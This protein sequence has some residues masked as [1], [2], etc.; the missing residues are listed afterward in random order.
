[1]PSIFDDFLTEDNEPKSLVQSKIGALCK[2]WGRANHYELLGVSRGQKSEDIKKQIKK[3][4][5]AFQRTYH[6]DK[7]ET[8]GLDEEN[9]KAIEGLQKQITEAYQT[10][11]DPDTEKEYN[12]SLP[13][14]GFGPTEPTT[15][16]YSKQKSGGSPGGKIP[17]MWTLFFD[18]SEFKIGF[19]FFDWDRKDYLNKAMSEK[20]TIEWNGEIFYNID[21]LTYAALLGKV[22]HVNKLLSSGFTLD[23]SQVEHSEKAK[24]QV[25]STKIETE[26]SRKEEMRKRQRQ[27]QKLYEKAGLGGPPK[28]LDEEE[29]FAE[30]LEK[31]KEQKRRSAPSTSTRGS[32]GSPRKKSGKGHKA[33]QKAKLSPEE[34]WDGFMKLS[35]KDEEGIKRYLE[36]Y[37]SEI[38]N[39]GTRI[40]DFKKLNADPITTDIF[41][42]AALKGKKE[43]VKQLLLAGHKVDFSKIIHTSSADVAAFKTID[44]VLESATSEERKII[45][46]HFIDTKVYYYGTNPP[47]DKPERVLWN[48][49]YKMGSTEQQDKLYSKAVWDDFLKIRSENV[50][51]IQRYL[52]TYSS[53]IRKLETRRFKYKDISPDDFIEVDIFTDAALS[54]E[55][56]HVKQLLLAGFKLDRSQFNKNPEI[57]KD[58]NKTIKS[59]L[60]NASVTE[61][62]K[63]IGSFTR[64]NDPVFGNQLHE[65]IYT[66]D[67]E[68]VNKLITEKEVPLDSQDKLGRTPL[69]IAAFKGYVEVVTALVAEDANVNARSSGGNTPLLQAAAGGNFQVVQFLVEKG[70]LHVANNTG[71]TPIQVAK[72]EEIKKFLQQ[73]FDEKKKVVSTAKSGIFGPL[74]D[75]TL[76]FKRTKEL[77]ESTIK[78]DS[79]NY[80]VD[81]A[82]LK[83]QKFDE[84]E[85][86]NATSRTLNCAI[87]AGNQELVD[88]LKEQ[89]IRSTS[90]TKAFESMA[91]KA[92]A[93]EEPAAKELE[94]KHGPGPTK[95]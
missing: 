82:V 22:E 54:G 46:Q 35:S 28:T 66:G 47:S 12:R 92:K 55:K 61:R 78:P 43:H 37:G 19:T 7:T 89:G 8:L 77:Y 32:K 86:E 45:Y 5:H 69:A 50:E 27:L 74:E 40:Y 15:P 29:K 73:T 81:M 14:S 85:L 71:K 38:N 68:R 13:D 60:K 87:L 62:E 42:Y 58:I 75:N 2:N 31:L 52:K 76:K 51:E 63:I 65:A 24:E 95:P 83:G 44:S 34:V 93:E 26:F 23:L 57:E 67:L 56:E 94:E 39:L 11:T 3:K 21:V 84:K 91:K 70:A 49:R 72:T 17:L 20:A 6:P 53:E 88:L 25:N 10:L 18:C 36:T 30:M 59:V 41:T 64:N 48:K 80:Q 33:Q 16:Q 4:Y 79:K 90:M 1:M 9:K